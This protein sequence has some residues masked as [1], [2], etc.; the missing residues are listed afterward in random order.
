[1]TPDT[2]TTHFNLS[3]YNSKSEIKNNQYRC[4]DIINKNKA[5]KQSEE[6][7]PFRNNKY[8]NKRQG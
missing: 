3:K 8:S 7:N 5:T 4:F 1:M 2:N 6:D